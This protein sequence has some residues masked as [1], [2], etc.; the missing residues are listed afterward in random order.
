MGFH[1]LNAAA[2]GFNQAA[3]ILGWC[4]VGQHVQDRIKSGNPEEADEALDELL[5]AAEGLC[6]LGVYL[7]E[8]V[9]A[10]IKEHPDLVDPKKV[11]EG[12]DGAWTANAKMPW[13]KKVKELVND[14]A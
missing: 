9:E 8:Y 7:L 2:S 10:K 6:K 12:W 13:L 11:E 5:T 4:R 14:N 1:E 3:G